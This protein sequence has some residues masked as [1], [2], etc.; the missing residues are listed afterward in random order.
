[1]AIDAADFQ[2][3]PLFEGLT[4]EELAT[5]A[6]RFEERTFLEGHHLTTEGALGYLF[7][8]ILEGT[9]KAQ[10]DDQ[11]VGRLGRGDVS[12]IRNAGARSGGVIRRR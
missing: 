2:Q 5:I 9:A 8:V 10:V 4:D 7:F 12:H 6:G 1:M 3:V 11:N